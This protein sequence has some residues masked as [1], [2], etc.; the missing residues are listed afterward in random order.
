VILDCCLGGAVP[1]PTV[2]VP[3]P[4][5][6]VPSPT[7]PSQCENIPRCA[8]LGLTGGRTV[9]FSPIIQALDVFSQS[10]STF[11]YVP[12]PL[13]DC[14]VTSDGVTL[15]CCLGGGAVPG[16]SPTSSSS[17]CEN[18]P[19]CAALGLT[20]GTTGLDSTIIFTPLSK[21]KPSLSLTQLFFPPWSHRLLRHV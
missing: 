18:I 8:A 17:Q 20:G 9:S 3:S 4:T 5:V 13:T 10:N 1:S 15:D 21:Q 6:P 7:F 11:F 16:P 19:A 14:C 12:W 2:P